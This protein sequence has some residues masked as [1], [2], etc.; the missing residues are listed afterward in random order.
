MDKN[1]TQQTLEHN[2]QVLKT[3]GILVLDKVDYMPTL[4]EPFISHDL[5]IGLILG[6]TAKVE[7]DTQL[8]NFRP[9]DM[10]VLMPNHTVNIIEVADDLDLMILIISNEKFERMKIEYPSGYNGNLHY[11]W[12]AHIRLDERLSEN[13][14]ALLRVLYSVCWSQSKRKTTLYHYMIESLFILLQDHCQENGITTYKPSPH[15]MIFSHFVDNVMK[16]YTESRE[17]SFYANL[18]CLSPKHFS[19]IIK[20]QTGKSAS[21]WISGYVIAQAK[22]LLYYHHHLSIQQ[23]SQRMGFPDQAS[24]ARYF[25][26][27]TGMSAREFREKRGG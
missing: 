9:N 7:Y 3:S 26:A 19:S 15:E 23:V 4:Q 10:F 24:F 6:G 13:I 14:H 2:R 18:F 22:S 25:K 16:H 20:Q 27:N 8:V 21:E 1:K 5:V 11:H 12:Q 17:V